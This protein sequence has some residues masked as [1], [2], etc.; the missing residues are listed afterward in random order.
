MPVLVFPREQP[1]SCDDDSEHV[2]RV[3]VGDGLARKCCVC[4]AVLDAL[5][6]DLKPFAWVPSLLRVFLVLCDFHLV[7]V[8]VLCVEAGVGFFEAAVWV[9]GHDLCVFSLVFR[10]H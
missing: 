8:T 1:C 2:E 9:A 4:A 7:Q 3:F 6:E 5:H 10:W